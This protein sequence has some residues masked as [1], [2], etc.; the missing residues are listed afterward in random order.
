ML[1]TGTSTLPV[2]LKMMKRTLVRVMSVP[3]D[4]ATNR[5][6]AELTTKLE[7]QIGNLLNAAAAQRELISYFEEH[8]IHLFLC[9]R[10]AYL[11]PLST[12]SIVQ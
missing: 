12:G 7:P 2:V 3:V 6:K 4:A 8:G 5:H 11:F 10:T 9:L 1:F